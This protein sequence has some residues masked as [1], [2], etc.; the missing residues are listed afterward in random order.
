[1]AKI[2]INKLPK[3]FK[4]QNGKVVKEMQQG[5]S[6]GD[7]NNYALTTY[8]QAY[9]S[10]NTDAADMRYSLSSVPREIA[11]IEA[12][13][14]ETV[15]TKLSDNG[16]FGLYNIKGPR[17]TSGGVPMYL[18][19]Q[20]FVFSDTKAM[21]FKKNELAEFGI[22]SKK[23]MT[24][25]AISKKYKLNEFIGAMNEDDV[26]PIKLKSAEL[27]LEKNQKGLSKLAFAQELKKQF[28]D[29]IPAT[30]HP[31][32]ISKGID[33]IKF[34]QQ[35]EEA[36][37]QKA[38]MEAIASTSPQKLEQMMMLQNMMQQAGQ[39]PEA[40]Y[41]M[42]LSKAQVGIEK[43]PD[44]NIAY[45]PN[46]GKA[47][48]SFGININDS[49]I[50]ATT[51]G[52]KQ[53]FQGSG[54]YGNAKDNLEGFKNAWQNI[55]PD[56]DNLIESLPNY[57]KNQRNPEV[58]KFQNWINSNYI[59][60]EVNKI[61]EK[62]NSK[63]EKISDKQLEELKKELL[64]D[65]G[66]KKGT[67]TD[68]DSLMGTYTSSRRPFS[69]TEPEIKK[70]ENE[71][72]K[73]KL[74]SLADP[75]F[76]QPKDP[77][78]NFYQQDLTRGA[79]MAMRDRTPYFPW[80]PELE[81][82][83]T[84]YVLEEPTRALAD[85]NEQYN[86]AAQAMGAFAGPQSL[87]ARLAQ[88]QGNAFKQNA[89]TFA[90]VNSRNINTVNQ[91]L[92]MNAQFRQRD[93]FESD[94]RKVKQY[95]DTQATLQNYENDKNFDREQ[96]ADWYA[97]A[98]DNAVNAYNLNSLYRFDI[99]PTTGGTID[100]AN[101]KPI[102]PNKL[103]SSSIKDERLKNMQTIYQQFGD[104]VDAVKG[105]KYL[106]TGEEDTVPGNAYGNMYGI[107]P[108]IVMAQRASKAKKGKEIKKYAIP[109]YT[110]KAGF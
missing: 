36:N 85:T 82:T 72:Q 41:G 67:G 60:E 97:N 90:Q 10:N 49:G 35:V 48:K 87:N 55:Y 52:N 24:P 9:K 105:A 34:T 83:K 109:F 8:P 96:Y 46:T 37:K 59:P 19:E 4:I 22:E 86:I 65:Y 6:T 104:K 106:E 69:Y 61:K 11:N 92:A 31:Y 3:G 71:K 7:Q 30:S 54:L 91:G 53:T 62:V 17:H 50:G 94:R 26:D 74:N 79:A 70:Q 77:N 73:D 93:N 100:L 51:Y 20:S 78:F 2:K 28:S 64:D 57:N 33:P 107:D 5:G 102:T 14:G 27:M 1:M 80:Q 44:K 40:S 95:D 84:D 101:V 56:I 75:E 38:S 98:L 81:R 29:G 47:Y 32:L 63:G 108:Q 68:F 99:D 25:A 12:E 110:G 15:L 42:E 23:S 43:K 21:K 88:A 39:M 66:F 76:N 45:D 58:E 18:P 89:N 103:R 13:G 16:E